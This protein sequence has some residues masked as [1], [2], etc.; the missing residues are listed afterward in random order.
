MLSEIK[1]RTLKANQP[2]GSLVYTGQQAAL[3][4]SIHLIRY[5]INDCQQIKVS[6]FSELPLSA[7]SEEVSWLHIQGLQD[8]Q[9]MEQIA[10]QFHLHPLTVEDILNVE[11]RP[12]IEEFEHYIFI[13]LKAI[14]QPDPHKNFIS[15]NLSLVIG[16]DFVLSFQDEHT[17]LFN[18][19]Q[20]R[21]CRH[22]DQWVKKGGS[23]YLA[24]RLLDTIVDSYFFIL[25][26]MND[27]LEKIENIII[28]NPT[29]QNARGLYQLKNRVL[30]IRKIIWPL[31]EVLNHLFS[32][33]GSLI[34]ASTK[35]YIRDIQDHLGQAMDI[36]ETFRD[37]LSNLLDV[38]LSYLSYR[39][40][41]IMKILTIITT[42]F[43]P[44]TFITSLFGMNFKYMP[45][46]TWRWSYPTVLGIMLVI[47]MLMLYYYRRKKWL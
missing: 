12:K 22:P 29:K 23:D 21:I 3:P 43:I 16:K 30:T 2:P 44:I 20:N 32:T 38:F 42:I 17:D 35:I 1:V 11:Q 25:D 6:A 40:N 4:P 18:Q 13:T 26:K 7:S 39:M 36:I 9:L 33:E 45:E 46:L 14:R 47:V 10:A 27:Q 37:M 24:Y 41:E 28:T 19:I 31:R 5:S 8:I 15:K 34:S